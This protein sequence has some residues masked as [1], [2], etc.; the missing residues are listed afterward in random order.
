MLHEFLSLKIP[1]KEIINEQTNVE[2]STKLVNEKFKSFHTLY[3]RKDDYDS[4]YNILDKF[5]HGNKL[6]TE[7]GL[8]N[9]LGVLL[10]GLP[11]TGKTTTIHAI[12]SYLQKNI[13][14]VNLSTVETNQQLQA[15]F[16]HVI[17]ESTGGGIIVFEDI[18]AM[19]NVVH[20]RMNKLIN[21]MDNTANNTSNTKL[22]LEYFLNLLQ[23]SL[24]RDGSIFIATTNH[25]ELLDP[26][27]CRVGRFDVKINMKL[28]DHYQ[29]ETIYKKF[30]GKSI[31]KN[32]LAQIEEDKYTPAEIIF[33]LVNHVD[34]TLNSDKVMSKFIN[35]A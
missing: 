12:A 19:T 11:G 34:S 29:I 15:V 25:I 1:P 3:L 33:H 26:A 18:D 7:Y 17:L 8:P 14:Y 22:T 6:Y 23:G 28:C 9:K 21:T 32:V 27:F 24:T 4:L 20:D 31:D 35:N 2:V 13:Y 16:D 10:Y 5:K 30:V